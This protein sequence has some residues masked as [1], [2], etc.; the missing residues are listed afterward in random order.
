MTLGATKAVGEIL[1]DELIYRC[2]V[3][4]S[5]EMLQDPPRSLHPQILLLLADKLSLSLPPRKTDTGQRRDSSGWGLKSAKASIHLPLL[6]KRKGAEYIHSRGRSVG[7]STSKIK[8][9]TW[10]QHLQ[11]S[12]W[13]QEAKLHVPLQVIYSGPPSWHGASCSD[14]WPLP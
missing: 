9:E 10:T 8:Q 3:P 11:P 6:Q 1:P 5:S 2:C 12:S 13:T 14:F 4:R 7:F